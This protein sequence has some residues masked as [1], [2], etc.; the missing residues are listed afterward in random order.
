M[1]EVGVISPG[2]LSL[3][4]ILSVQGLLEEFGRFKML[5]ELFSIKTLYFY[6]YFYCEK[7]IFIN[8]SP[9]ILDNIL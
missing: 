3:V 4:Y 8:T 2:T 9:Y 6:F 5:L 1:F 7:I